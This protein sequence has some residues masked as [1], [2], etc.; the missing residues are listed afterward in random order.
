MVLNK[1]YDKFIF[2][3]NL[4]YKEN[5]FYLLNTP[6]VM[7]PVRLLGSLLR[8]ETPQF[9]QSLYDSVKKT[10]LENLTKEFLQE[11]EMDP[12]KMLEFF[13]TYFTASGFGFLQNIDFDLEQKHAM[14]TLTNNPLVGRMDFFSELP[15]DHIMRGVLAG[16]FSKA[17]KTSL[18]CVETQCS[19]FK[20]FNACR[21]M[22][23]PLGEFDIENKETRRQLNFEKVLVSFA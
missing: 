1:F 6:F 18:E 11:G 20:K 8:N 13:E 14:V 21:F 16:L 7:L 3:N 4:R 10:T 17:M 9:V 5:N 2:S 15:I 23:K 19:V 22:I 12:K